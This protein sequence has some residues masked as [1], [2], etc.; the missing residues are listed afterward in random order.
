MLALETFDTTDLIASG[1]PPR[2]VVAPC[3][4]F[5]RLGG[6]KFGSLHVQVNN[7]HKSQCAV[8]FAGPSL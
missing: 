8:F 7:L 2:E 1:F 4:G 6:P 5:A 3:N